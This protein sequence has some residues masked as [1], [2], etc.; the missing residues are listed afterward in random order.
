[1]RI[2]GTMAED[3]PHATQLNTE[4]VRGVLA[5][6]GTLRLYGG[7]RMGSSALVAGARLRGAGCG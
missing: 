2:L 6:R 7:A 5:P 1:M 4:V 3:A